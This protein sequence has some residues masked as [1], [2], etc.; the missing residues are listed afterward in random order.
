MKEQISNR[1]IVWR[2]QSLGIKA[3][4]ASSIKTSSVTLETMLRFS[5]VFCLSLL[6]KPYQIFQLY[7]SYIT[8][9]YLFCQIDFP[10]L[11]KHFF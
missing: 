5:Q 3:V 7:K 2:A 9:I 1:K 6:L 4:R 11:V 8:S 10:L